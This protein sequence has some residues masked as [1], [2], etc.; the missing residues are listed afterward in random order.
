M[1]A[2]V[3]RLQTPG[4]DLANSISHGLGVVS[5]VVGTPFLV[6]AA[7]HKGGAWSIIGSSIF[8]AAVAMLYLASTL[9]HGLPE[10]N[11]KRIF[12]M[13]DHGAIFLLIAG[14]YTP[15]TLGVLRGPWGWTLFGI[16]WGLAAV[17]LFTVAHP[18]T[19]HHRLTVALYLAM[20]WMIV[21][22]LRP[23]IAAVPLPGI[24]LLV[25]GG[26]AYTGGVIFYA[27]DRLRYFHLVWHVFVLAG[28]TLHFF[29]VL[30]YSA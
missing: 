9:Y 19:R 7:Y 3:K 2:E 5:I 11:A 17:G 20:G 1:T 6:L 23:L 13:I 21:I 22:A 26:L 14:T 18:R 28:T 10:G 27:T 30:N 29:A 4:E 15:F 24:L 25:A 16:I 12:R 8:A